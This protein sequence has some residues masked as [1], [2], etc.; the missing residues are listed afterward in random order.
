ML[1]SF[2]ALLMF[3]SANYA[4]AFAFRPSLPDELPSCL[5]SIASNEQ[6]TAQAVPWPRGY[7][8][9]VE[10]VGDIAVVKFVCRQILSE[11]AIEAVGRQL[12]A[13]VEQE[14]QRKLILNFAKLDRLATA[15]LGKLLTLHLK[16]KSCGG[17]LVLCQ[18]PRHLYEI[19]VILRLPQ[20]LNVYLDEQEALQRLTR[21]A[22]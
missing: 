10:T 14:G 13:L 12:S 20:L 9:E 18:I 21:R 19:F 15:M 17:W 6:R 1:F 4:P 5:A 11:E 16:L 7:L 2:E 3:A 8:L 22:G